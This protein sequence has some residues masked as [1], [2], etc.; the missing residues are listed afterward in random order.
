MQIIR[1]YAAGRDP[2]S[3]AAAFGTEAAAI[4][5]LVPEVRALVPDVPPLS[6]LPP[7]QARFRFFDAMASFLRRAATAETLV[8]LLDD[9]H[10][11]DASSLRFL[12][13][14]AHA[15]PRSRLLIVA[16]YR[17]V[18][19][20]LDATLA[21]TIAAL[22]REPDTDR[23]HLAGLDAADV[24]RV[25]AGL[26]GRDPGAALVAAVQARTEGNPFFVGEVVQLLIGD[27]AGFDR[28][29]APERRPALLPPNVRDVIRQRLRRLTPACY[30][31]LGVAAVLGREFTV[32]LLA[33]AWGA[34]P[35][36]VLDTME[37]AEAARLIS[38]VSSVSGGFRFVHALV[39]ETLYAELTTTRRVRLHA[40]LAAILERVYGDRA[41]RHASELAHHFIQAAVLTTDHMHKAA[42]YSRLAAEQAEGTT[43]WEAAARHYERCLALVAQAEDTLGQDEAVLLSAHS[44]CRRYS[45]EYRAGWGSAMRAITVYR[46]RGDR[47]GLARATLDALAFKA[48]VSRVSALAE[49]ALAALGDREP[50]LEARLLTEFAR[51]LGLEHDRARHAADRAAA[52]ARARLP[53]CRRVSRRHRGAARGQRDAARRRL[54]PVAIGA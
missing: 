41:T 37:E 14:L 5:E 20:A 36:D 29:D 31:L 49:A 18:D 16:A 32:A 44:R 8:L 22:V 7:E 19:V 38:D 2:S 52:L 21:A 26:A 4:A 46:E 23:L 50:Y 3:L 6:P 40:E 54:R 35:V 9:L 47:S 1:A 48:P 51:A 45:G 30:Q 11:A 28:G 34:S 25:I 17:D 53:R 42:L 10:W 39:Q 13:F 27:D 24:A 15:P 43:A 33:P 12:Q